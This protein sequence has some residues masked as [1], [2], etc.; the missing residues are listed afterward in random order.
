MLE[1][2]N[3]GLCCAATFEMLVSSQI[4]LHLFQPHQADQMFDP[5]LTG[6]S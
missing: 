1:V 3:S 5:H 6:S 2:Q 4:T